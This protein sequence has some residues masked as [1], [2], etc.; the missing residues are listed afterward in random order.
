MGSHR[1][2]NKLVVNRQRREELQAELSALIA[3]RT[4]LMTQAAAA[5]IPISEIEWAAGL[6]G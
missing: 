1:L 3:E 6:R 5:N 4:D 2:V